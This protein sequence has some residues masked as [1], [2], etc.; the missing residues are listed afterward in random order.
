LSFTFKDRVTLGGIAGALG[1]LTRDVYSLFAKI[2]GLA[3]FYVWNIS[4]DLFMKGKDTHTFFGHLVGFLADIAMGSILGIIFVYFLKFTSHKNTIIK[5]WGV[6][7]AAWLLLFGIMVHNLPSVEAAPKDA[8]SNFSAFIGHSIFGISMGI[9][10]Q[11]LLKKFGLLEEG[12]H[13]N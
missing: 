7:L 9:Y 10:A 1:L 4:A 5:G 13:R 12:W 11:T 8:L 6:G 3:K 2:T